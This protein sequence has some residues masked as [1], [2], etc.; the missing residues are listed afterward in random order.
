MKLWDENC[1]LG[2]LFI[3]LKD[4]LK[5]YASYVAQ[6]DNALTTLDKYVVNTAN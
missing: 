6:Y 5:M 2:D 3:M 1:C 4:Y